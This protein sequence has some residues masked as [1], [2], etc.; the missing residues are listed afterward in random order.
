MIR[1][2][3]VGLAL[4]V[5][6]QAAIAQQ[7]VPPA[8]PTIGASAGA[9]AG[10]AIPIGRL[11]ETH[12]AGYT[13]AGLVD[14]SAAEQPFSFRGEFIYQHYDR[15]SGAA[16]GV[17]SKNITSLGASLLARSPQKGASTFL[18][19]GIAVYRLTDEG[20]KPGINIGAG[21]EVPLT[22]FIGIADVRLHFVLT[23][24]PA[25]TIPITLGARF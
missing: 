20:T 7:T 11:S 15:K 2:V 22:F 14:F 6:S 4:A 8:A 16:A 19:G 12:S 18:L 24:K 1:Y 10:I 9:G 3:A 25:L 13:V 23:D 21:I 5:V 17:R